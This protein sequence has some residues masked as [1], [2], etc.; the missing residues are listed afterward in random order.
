MISVSRCEYSLRKITHPDAKIRDL[1][2]EICDFF[3]F[4]Q[5]RRLQIA[6]LRSFLISKRYRRGCY[7]RRTGID[8]DNN[9]IENNLFKP[10]CIITDTT[11]DE[12]P[13]F[14]VS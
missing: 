14:I 5:S 6:A 12:V 1:K 11:K 3:F 7:R 13:S 2:F 8:L 9:A 10:K 4:L